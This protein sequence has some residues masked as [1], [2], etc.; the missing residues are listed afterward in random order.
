METQEV[1]LLMMYFRRDKKTIQHYAN[2]N[3]NFY[4]SI[5]LDCYG[6]R[7]C[8]IRGVDVDKKNLEL[9]INTVRK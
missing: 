4:D 3:R 8:F 7:V 1:C 9:F 5:Y 2:R 6:Q